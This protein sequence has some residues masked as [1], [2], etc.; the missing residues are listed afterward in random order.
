[1]FG[2]GDILGLKTISDKYELNDGEAPNN[3]LFFIG[4]TFMAG[5]YM[6]KFKDK[7]KFIANLQQLINYDLNL[8]DGYRQLLA[9]DNVTPK[10][11]E[12][13]FLKLINEADVGLG[14][15]K[16]STTLSNWNEVVLNSSEPDSEPI[17][18]PCN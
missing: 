2:L 16:A 7:D 11:I 8:V 13:M 15:F 4:G 14:L 3:S 17:E 18:I 5:Q 6:I 9:N 10:N 1:M 12:K